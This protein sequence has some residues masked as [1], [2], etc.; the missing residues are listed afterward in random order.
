IEVRV[1]LADGTIVTAGPAMNEDLW[2]A[3]RGGTGGN[4]GVVL[5]EIVQL[6]RLGPV[7]GRAVRWP[8]STNQDRGNAMGAL[9]LLQRQDMLTAP[10]ELNPQVMICYQSVLGQSL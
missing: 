3:V 9:S 1:M 4:F 6:R 8:L 5:T 7:Y 2:W 10:D